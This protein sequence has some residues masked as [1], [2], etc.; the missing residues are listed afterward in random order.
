MIQC[1]RSIVQDAACK[2]EAEAVRNRQMFDGRGRARID[3][4]HAIGVIPAERQTGR[5]GAVDGHVLPEGQR[6]RKK[7]DGF[8][9][10]G[11]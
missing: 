6:T 3:D 8:I 7:C 4:E 1:Q 9:C 11:V 5:S 2:L 10:K